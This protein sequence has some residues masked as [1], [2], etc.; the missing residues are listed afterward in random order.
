MSLA[1]FEQ[2]EHLFVEAPGQHHG[3][4]APPK[5]IGVK[6]GRT[7]LRNVDRPIRLDGR[8]LGNGRV[9]VP[10]HQLLNGK[11]VLGRVLHRLIGIGIRPLRVRHFQFG[12]GL[13]RFRLAGF[14]GGLGVGGIVIIRHVQIGRCEKPSEGPCT[15]LSAG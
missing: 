11:V 12:R 4:Q 13:L 6:V 9:A 7:E 3:A 2:G 14:V 10:M 5:S 15:S 1:L 8:D